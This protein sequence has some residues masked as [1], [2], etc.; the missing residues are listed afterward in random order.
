VF[1]NNKLAL[2]DFDIF[3]AAGGN[4]KPVTR[5]IRTAVRGDKLR[6]D[7]IREAGGSPIINGLEIFRV[8]Q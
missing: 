4:H 3:T 1:I 7:F 2:N 6:I 5:D 8:N